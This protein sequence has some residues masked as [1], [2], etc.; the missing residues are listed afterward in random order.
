M[1]D[2]VIQLI[3][4]PLATINSRRE[5]RYLVAG[6]TSEGIEYFSFLLLLALFPGFLYLW[7]SVSFVLGVLSGFYFHK[8]WTFRGEQQFKTH[9]QFIGYVALAGVN[10]VAINAFLGLYVETFKLGPALAKL[11][12]IATTVVWT[13]LISN[14]IIF[15]HRD[16]KQ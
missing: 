2:L 3:K 13:Y 7:N 16:K 9:Q 11:L 12:A 6:T 5:L 10:F 1:K 4:H 14:Y 15:R 8:L